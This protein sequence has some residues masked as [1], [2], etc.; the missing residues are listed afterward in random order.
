MSR[1]PHH[2]SGPSHILPRNRQSGLVLIIFLLG[3]AA[4]LPAPVAEAAPQD[5]ARWDRKYQ[6]EDYIFGKDPIPFLKEVSDLLPKRGQA[7]DLAAGEGRNAVFLATLGLDITAIDIS[8]EGLKKAKALARERGV[9]IKT[10]AADL[11]SYRLPAKTY[12]VIVCTYY[13]QRDL[14][15]KMKAALKPGGMIVMETYTQDH[16]KYRP[17]FPQDYLLKPNELLKWFDDFVILRYQLVDDGQAVY[18][19]I[20]A[21]KPG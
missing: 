11:E 10:I 20:L 17:R 18:A 14:I 8:E 7:L 13:L 21:Q 16:H 9:S 19:S 1:F 6:T 15:P 5:K 12:D 2:R 4:L 3:V